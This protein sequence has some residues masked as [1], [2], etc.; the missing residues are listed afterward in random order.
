RP[1]RPAGWCLGAQLL[2]RRVVETEDVI[3]R[4]GRAPEVLL[5][6][7]GAA[8]PP[9]P[10]LP[11]P[12]LETAPRRGGGL[13]AV[14]RGPPAPEGRRGRGRR[15]GG[16][17]RRGRK[18]GARRGA[19]RIGRARRRCHGEGRIH[20]RGSVEI[21]QVLERVGVLVARGQ[22]RRAEESLLDEREQG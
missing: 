8:R 17:G 9:P 12:D 21:E 10:E 3:R 1:A 4:R 20:R 16:R 22:E 14:R 15:G 18:R 19:T 5:R 11:V 7:E 6:D 13:T 2:A